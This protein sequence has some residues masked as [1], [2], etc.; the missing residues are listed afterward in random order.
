M[1]GRDHAAR[2]TANARLARTEL[3]LVSEKLTPYS[4]PHTFASLLFEAGAT[5]PYVMARSGT[6]T[7]R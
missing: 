5:G 6:P 4:L 3:P 2:S 1:Q 7:R